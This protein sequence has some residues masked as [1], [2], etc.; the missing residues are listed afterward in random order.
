M[1]ENIILA[2]HNV[3]DDWEYKLAIE[4]ETNEKWSLMVCLTN[5]LHG[6]TFKEL[7]RYIKYFAFS[8]KIFLNRKKYSKIIAWQQFYGL[9]IAFYCKLFNVKEYPDIYVMTFIYKPKKNKIYNKFINYIVKSGC[10]KKFIVL[11]ESEIEYYSNTF[12]INKENFYFIPIGVND[13]S[14]KILQQKNIGKY[15]L[16]VGRSNRDY[17]F[18]RDS[19]KKEYG[20]L[21]IISDSYNEEE[22]ENI[23]CISNC[24]GDNYLQMLANSYAEIIPLKDPEISSGSLSFLQ[25]MM[26]SKPTIVTENKT[27]HDYIISSNNGYII[28]KNEFALEEAIK[29]LENPETYMRISK[30]ARETFVKQYSETSLGIKTAKMIM[31][32]KIEEEEIK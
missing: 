16:S 10:V 11:S 8:F 4:N 21:V 25:A 22:K 19:W 14:K 2:D 28:E 7:L 31:A 24:Y 6:N 9:L 29:K 15:Y 1:K 12:N 20:K 27:V 3:S 17:T 30:N 32:E 18:L 5:R 13:V 26:L 23:T